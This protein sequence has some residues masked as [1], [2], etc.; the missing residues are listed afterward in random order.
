MERRKERVTQLLQQYLEN[1]LTDAEYNEMWE[2][3]KENP[4]ETYFG[5]ELQQLWQKAKAEQATISDAEWDYKMQMLK[6]K[7]S[8]EKV[9]EPA[10]Q[11]RTIRMPKYWWAAAAALLIFISSAVYLSLNTNNKS[12]N[13]VVA[14]DSN[15]K[16][17]HDRLP[18]GDKAILTLADGT[19]I[20]LD[21]AGNGILAQQ[22]STKIIKK[23][24]GQLIYNTSGIGTE[25]VAY[26][27]LATPR[28]GQYKL[29]L[30]D[31][32]K[33]WLNA[34]SSLKY[35]AAFTSHTRN[36]EITGEAYFEIAKDATK[37]FKVKVNQME[38]EVLGTHFNINGYAD[39]DMIRTT[40]LEGSVKVNTES[41][42]SFLKPG[43]QAQLPKTGKVK[44]LNNVD[45]EET[46]AWKEGNFQFENSDI[47]TVMRQITRWYDVDVE[48]NGKVTKHFL[49]TIT[50]NVNLTQVLAMLQQT[51]EVKFKIEGRKVLVMP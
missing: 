38:V 45:I 47:N 22:G 13:E 1:Q 43:Q 33:V 20:V 26:N 23:Q 39:E 51:G 16:N 44:V 2:L 35:P 27:T 24:D 3:L 12:N 19:S 42:T 8:E 7:L 31:G 29:T 36:V 21:S 32:S 6:N 14:N 34:A 9:A 5:K 49:G 28:G 4:D 50:R 41:G 25:E 48:Y 18:G 15:T 37:P 11:K 17:L 30:P 10:L 46:I 40:L